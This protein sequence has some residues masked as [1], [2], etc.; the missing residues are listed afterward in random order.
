MEQVN[1]KLDEKIIEKTEDLEIH[2]AK[3]LTRDEEEK[4]AAQN[5][6]LVP[7]FKAEK[8][9]MDCKKHWD[10][11]YKRNDTRFF[12]D[13]HWTTREFEELLG[14][15][16]SSSSNGNAAGG[17]VLLEI[18]CGVGNLIFPLIEDG[19]QFKKIFACDLSS[20]AIELLKV[21]ERTD[22]F[23]FSLN[24]NFY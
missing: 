18:G 7:Q 23:F 9:E 6:R 4:M 3:G 10:L 22:G 16:L 19:L 21:R 12:K 15:G 24:V 5:T 11:F 17:G 14:A 20:R 13:R 8:L 1:D 2:V